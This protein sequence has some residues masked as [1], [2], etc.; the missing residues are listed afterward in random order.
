[1]IIGESEDL[2]SLAMPIDRRLHVT[3]GLLRD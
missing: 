1:M 2:L 3:I